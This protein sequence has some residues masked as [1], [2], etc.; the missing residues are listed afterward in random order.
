MIPDNLSN[1]KGL[2]TKP[3]GDTCKVTYFVMNHIWN[4]PPRTCEFGAQFMSTGSRLG[5]GCLGQGSQSPGKGT[6]WQ[7]LPGDRQGRQST[8]QHLPKGAVWTLRD[9]VRHPLS[10]I[11]HPLEDPGTR[12]SSTSII[13]N[14]NIMFFV[15]LL[16]LCMT[17]S[18]TGLL[19]K[20]QHL[21]LASSGLL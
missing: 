19:I 5:A 17:R 10:S 15:F 3:V 13:L 6:H 8:Y 14:Q 11:Q 12:T 1:S 2:V 9:G 21:L 7:S 16:A 20:Q 4:M 18:L